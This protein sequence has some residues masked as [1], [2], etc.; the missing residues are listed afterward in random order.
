MASYDVIG[1]KTSIDL[2]REFG[3]EYD[4]AN[5]LVRNYGSKHAREICQV[6]SKTGELQPI[7]PNQHIMKAEIR[8]A[9]DHEMAETVSDVIGHRTRLAFIDP[10]ET[11]QVLSDL[12]EDIGNMKNWSNE[13]R[14]KEYDDAKKFL[15]TMIYE[16]APEAQ[17]A[18][19][20]RTYINTNL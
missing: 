2:A 8:W 13:R 14:I 5:H 4:D 15:S 12:V 17:L 11:Q 3:I 20:K 19:R 16:G 6:G 7:I 10:R 9:V 18:Q 1:T